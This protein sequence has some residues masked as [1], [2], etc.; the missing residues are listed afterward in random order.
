MPTV[1]FDSLPDDARV[2][3]FAS[4]RELAESAER[5]LLS[6]VDEFL[7]GW[8]AHGS[9]LRCAR[10]WRDGHFLAI[11]VDQRDASA[12]GCSIDGLFRTLQQLGPELQTQLIGGGRV[13]YRDASGHPRM[14]SRTAITARLGA[15]II[16]ETPVFDLSVATAGDYRE[17]FER[18]ARETWIGE[19]LAR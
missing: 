9:P 3:I 12:S 2:W 8:T 17:R 18:P 13:F 5:R 19:R 11:G 7:A 6:A 10:E 14:V 1:P 16:D 15:D 4:D